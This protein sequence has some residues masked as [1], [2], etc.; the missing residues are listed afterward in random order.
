MRVYNVLAISFAAL[1][2]ITF[3]AGSWTWFCYDV[4]WSTFFAIM[5]RDF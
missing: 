3:I 5:G 4:V 2:M 1:A